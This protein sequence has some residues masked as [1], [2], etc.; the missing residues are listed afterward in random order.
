M[1]GDSRTKVFSF[2]TGPCKRLVL[3]RGGFVTPVPASHASH[4]TF[5]IRRGKGLL[6]KSRRKSAGPFPAVAGGCVGCGRVMVRV[7]YSQEA[8]TRTV[9]SNVSEE[10]FSK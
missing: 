7:L 2:C 1:V 9:H 6:G 3:S 10:N 4:R 8:K 5:A